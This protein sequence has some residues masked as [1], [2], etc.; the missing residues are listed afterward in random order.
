MISSKNNLSYAKYRPYI[1]GLRAFSVFFVIF[2]MHFLKFLKQ[3][4]LGQIFFCNLGYLI[5]S[6]IISDLKDK[7]YIV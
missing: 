2:T 7:S 1:D 5:P 4:L 6:I 3:V